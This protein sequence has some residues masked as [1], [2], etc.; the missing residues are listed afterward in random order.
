[1]S[2]RDIR[3]KIISRG[4]PCRGCGATVHFGKRILGEKQLGG[5]AIANPDG[6]LHYLTCTDRAAT[7]AKR[8]PAR[9][10]KKTAKFKPTTS[11]SLVVGVCNDCGK[12]TR[13][14]EIDWDRAA[15]PRCRLCGG[16]LQRA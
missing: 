14:K 10:K 1:M 6:T 4:F 3:L 5:K 13:T 9:R 12:T 2:E 16:L 8:P 11:A 15:R 7:K